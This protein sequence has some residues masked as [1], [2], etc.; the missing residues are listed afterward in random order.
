[1]IQLKSLLPLCLFSISL[2]F[3][4]TSFAKRLSILVPGGAFTPLYG[5]NKTPVNLSDFYLDD[6]PVT[7]L[8]F[9]QFIRIHPEWSRSHVKKIFVDKNY[10][11]HWKA[12]LQLGA[13]SQMEGPVVFVSWYAAKS[14]CESEGK[15]LPSVNEWEF[16]ASRPIPGQDVRKIILNWYSVPTPEVLPKVTS[17]F[18]NSLGIYS[19]HGLIWEWTSDFNS[20][21][22]T[23]ESRADGS[24]D[25]TLFCGSG[26]SNAADKLDYA[27]FL[28]FGF[29]SSLK[30]PYAIANLGFR[31][32]KDQDSTGRN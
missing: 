5:T 26:S 15:R 22:I 4:I 23:G 27:A 24:L 19:M 9:L 16:V 17:G 32:A 8:E 29:R 25:K 20:T 31:C 3:S 6:R 21:M 14:F 18:K 28:R 11:S 12:D 30:A 2:C 13:N 1:M 10:L 7:N